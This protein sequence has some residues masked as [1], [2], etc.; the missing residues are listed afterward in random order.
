MRNSSVDQEGLVETAKLIAD[1][2]RSGGKILIFGN[3]GS[4]TDA[5]DFCVDL[6][7]PTGGMK[8]V[9]AI[10]LTNDAA[11]V[12]AVGNDVG[13]ENIFAR[14]VIAY[15]K[16]GDV[17][18]AISTSGG[19]RNVLAAVDEARQRGLLTVALAGYGGGRLAELCDRAHTISAD[20]IPRIQEAQAPQYHILRRLL[21]ELVP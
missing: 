20:Y 18:F 1:R 4:A 2:V 5:Q 14:Q 12:T 17:A 13:F 15:G 6:V 16:P 9:P 3:G 10:S 21:G 8:P 19:S 11:V 7:A